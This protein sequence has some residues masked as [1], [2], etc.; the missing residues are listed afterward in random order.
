MMEAELEQPRLRKLL[1]Y[2]QGKR[3]DRPYPARAD[4]DPAELLFMLGD[5]IL[6][7]IESG[8][9]DQPRFRYRLFGS[10]IARRQGFDMTGKYIDEHPWQG[11][12]RRASEGYLR[13]TQTGAPDLIT[14]REEID[15]RLFR[16]QSLLLPLGIGCAVTPYQVNKI[17]VGVSFDADR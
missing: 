11:F 10:N 4:I 14:R 1:A 7:D 9:D 16:H 13:V 12:A 5:L 17:L 2:W 8:E 3:G 15:G 6:F